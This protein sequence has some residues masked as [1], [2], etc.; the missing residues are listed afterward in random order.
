MVVMTDSNQSLPQPPWAKMIEDQREARGY[1]V[2]KAAQL[3]MLSDSFWG[4]AE[5]GWKPYKGK[6]HRPLLPSRKTLLQ[7]TEA[8]RL[9]AAT[10]NLILVLAGYQ[11]V[12]TV[13]EKP[14]PRTVVD[15]RGLNQADINL[16]NLF[17]KH[18]RDN[19]RA[20]VP[21]STRSESQRP[22]PR[23]ASNGGD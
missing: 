13:G 3:A 4:M 15:L 2:R 21:Q 7:M 11:P 18:L 16:L 23:T 17:S 19:K 6:P 1:S 20:P 14:D 22:H 12:L 5:R 10:T 8:L 9:P